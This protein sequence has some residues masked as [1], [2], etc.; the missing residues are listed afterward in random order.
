M[1]VSETSLVLK[2]E[3]NDEKKPKWHQFENLSETEARDFLRK[4][5]CSSL[6]YKIMDIFDKTIKHCALE[7]KV[8]H[9]SDELRLKLH[10]KLR[11]EICYFYPK[12][13]KIYPK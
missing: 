7:K 3:V 4:K 11:P 6:L 2:N 8:L 1:F 9:R 5:L 10:Q 12:N 13:P